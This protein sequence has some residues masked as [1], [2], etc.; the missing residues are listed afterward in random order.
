MFKFNE[1]SPRGTWIVGHRGAMAHAPENSFASFKLGLEM[2]ADFLE[3]DV[4]LSKD[5]QGIVMHDERLERTTNGRGFIKDFNASDIKKLDAGSW[6]SKKFKGETVPLLEELLLWVKEQKSNLGLPVGLVI[7]IKNDPI[8][9]LN[10]EDRVLETVHKTGMAPR[11]ILISFD[12][13]VVKRAKLL[14]ATVLTGIL[15][16]EPLEDPCYTARQVAADAIFP[17]RNLA[18]QILVEKA[19]QQKLFMAPWTVNEEKE[20]QE[21]IRAGV[22]AMATNFPDRLN[23]ILSPLYAP[24]K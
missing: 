1:R 5:N 24:T 13:G 15:Y 22:D 8:R 10:I 20:M 11:V 2:G 17:R 23:K 9:Y 7:E 4:H 16:N 18:F 3:C 6:H 19:H 21:L 14:D 12:Q